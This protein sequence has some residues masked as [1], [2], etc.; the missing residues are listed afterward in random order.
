MEAFALE[1]VTHYIRL[2]SVN[3]SLPNKF[4]VFFE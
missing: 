3:V 1:K 4:Y 2:K